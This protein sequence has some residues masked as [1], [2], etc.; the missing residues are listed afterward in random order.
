MSKVTRMKMPPPKSVIFESRFDICDA[1]M[2][3]IGGIQMP[4]VVIGV[5]F[6]VGKVLYDIDL[7]VGGQTLRDVDS[8]FVE[9]NEA[10]IHNLK[11]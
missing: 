2:L 7:D 4:G 3:S 9:P 5:R 6:I 1:V 10:V 8:T 11:G